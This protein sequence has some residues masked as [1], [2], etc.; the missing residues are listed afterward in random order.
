MASL[1]SKQSGEKMKKLILWLALTGIGAGL[2]FGQAVPAKSTETKKQT[3]TAPSKES[4]T[5][6]TTAQASTSGTPTPKT[7]KDGTPDKRYKE[8]KKLKKDGTP[9]MRYKEN[10]G[11]S[12]AP[13]K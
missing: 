9:D 6:A 13:S 7:K 1:R 4:G 2:S 11:K 5:Q 3:T 10:Q 8:N 12:A